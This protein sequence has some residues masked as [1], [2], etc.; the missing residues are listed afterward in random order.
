MKKLTKQ[1]EED[2]GK[3]ITAI[4][5]SIKKDEEE[6]INGMVALMKKQSAIMA[7]AKSKG[8]KIEKLMPRIKVAYENSN[9]S[10]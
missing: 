1:E 8:L 6:F 4:S 7:V 5:I 9:L 2:I 3:I 10:L